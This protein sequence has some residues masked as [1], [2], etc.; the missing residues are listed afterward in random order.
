MAN[1]SGAA[2][3]HVHTGAANGQVRPD[4][5]EGVQVDA[6]GVALTDGAVGPMVALT[7]TA[8]AVIAIVANILTA[9]AAIIAVEGAAITEAPCGGRPSRVVPPVVRAVVPAFRAGTLIAVTGAITQNTV[10][11]ADVAA[12]AKVAGAAAWLE[13]VAR[14]PGCGTELAHGAV[15][16]R[17]VLGLT[18]RLLI[19]AEEP[20]ALDPTADLAGF[21]T[22][23]QVTGQTRVGAVVASAV[24]LGMVR[25]T[26]DH[27]SESCLTSSGGKGLFPSPP[28]ETKRLQGASATVIT[29]LKRIVFPGARIILLRGSFGID[30]SRLDADY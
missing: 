3:A 11:E 20:N 18:T 27:E 28:P 22:A 25:S 15:G 12:R 19:G 2:R 24:T 21:V 23:V 17:T 1:T 14:T 5:A 26:P 8:V 16:T 9:G 13:G 4:G 29:S 10:R 30:R 7:P 6:Q